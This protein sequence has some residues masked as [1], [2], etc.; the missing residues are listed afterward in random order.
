VAVARLSELAHHPQATKADAEYIT[1]LRIGLLG[2]VE[3]LEAVI[4]AKDSKW[5][6][7]QF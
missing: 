2:F 1:R 7:Q 6:V 4:A 5:L 3:Q